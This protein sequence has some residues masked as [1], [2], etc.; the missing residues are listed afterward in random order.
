MAILLAQQGRRLGADQLGALGDEPAEKV[1]VGTLDLGQDA[2]DDL[3][4]GVGQPIL[5]D[6]HP[7]PVEL[8]RPHALL[9]RGPASLRQPPVRFV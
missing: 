7:G 4:A 8:Q 9:D 2:P 3:R 6:L 1:V 5:V